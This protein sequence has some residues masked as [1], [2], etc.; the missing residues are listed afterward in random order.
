MYAWNASG[1][2]E[3]NDVRAVLGGDVLYALDRAHT[4]PRV[5]VEPRLDSPFHRRARV[6]DVEGEQHRLR[7]RVAADEQG[8]MPDRVAGRLEQPQALR[9]LDVARHRLELRALVIPRLV[10]VAEELERLVVARLGELLLVHDIRD[11]REVLVA[12]DVVEVEV[13]VDERR[14]V[15]RREAGELELR[16][17]RLLRGLLGELEREHGV[18]VLEVEA[19]V[20]EEEPVVVLDEHAVRRDPHLRPRH[21]PHELRVLDDDRAVVEQPDLHRCASSASRALR[22]ATSFAARSARRLVDLLGRVV[23]E[24]AARLHAELALRRSCRGSS[25]TPRPTWRGPG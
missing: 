25:T 16:G 3:K 1:S 17:D 5:D 20:E 19:G 2:C 10:R 14:H 18:R 23:V 24:A 7:R 12:A 15:G 9:E 22:T 6:D 11:A 8:V 13:G 4:G 21:V